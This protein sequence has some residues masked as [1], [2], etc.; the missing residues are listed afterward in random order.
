MMHI[1]YVTDIIS[2][3]SRFCH[4]VSIFSSLS[5][6]KTFYSAF[7]CNFNC[8]FCLMSKI[9][10]IRTRFLIFPQSIVEKFSLTKYRIGYNMVIMYIT[11]AVL[12]ESNSSPSYF[13]HSRFLN[14]CCTLSNKSLVNFFRE[15]GL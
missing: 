6:T 12:H 5:V 15:G 13:L 14:F 2:S 9:C 7:K 8:N 11:L 4:I 10:T 1:S 3:V